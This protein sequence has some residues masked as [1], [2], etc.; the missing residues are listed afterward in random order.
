MIDSIE[1]N[2]TQ[3]ALKVDDGKNC[4]KEAKKKQ[5]SFRKK[6]IICIAVASGAVIL[7]VVIAVSVL[8]S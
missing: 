4:L 3:A 2:V 7:A 1:I 5:S 8:F 6:K